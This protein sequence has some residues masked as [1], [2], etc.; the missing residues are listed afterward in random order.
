MSVQLRRG[1][2]LTTETVVAQHAQER[3]GE[4]A[5]VPIAQGPTGTTF[6]QLNDCADSALFGPRE[7][8]QCD[9]IMVRMVMAAYHL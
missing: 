3:D 9:G 7:S 6:S 1:S 8:E 4:P 5:Q 2:E